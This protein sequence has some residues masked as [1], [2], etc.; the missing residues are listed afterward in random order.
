MPIL[1]LLP[2]RT[3]DTD[4]IRAAA[5]QAG[6]T[7]EQLESWRVPEGL[8]GQD[9]VLYGEPLF[10][11][12]VTPTLGLALLEP[13]SDWTACLPSAY[14]RREVRFTTLHEA[15][16]LPSRSFIKPADDKCFPAAV[17]ASGASLPANTC[18]LPDTTSVLLSEPIDWKVEFRCFVLDRMV[19]T[20][21]PYWRMG[22]LAQA[23]DGGWPASTHETDTALGFVELVLADPVVRLSAAVVVDVGRIAHRRWAV[24]EANAA[25]GSGIYGCDA[26]R[27]LPVLARASRP[28]NAVSE[29]DADWIRRQY[30]IEAA[31]QFEG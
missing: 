14:R 29:E 28:S 3:S 13:S 24:V 22:T 6:W 25:W 2:R 20:F 7:I 4:A 10:A 27:I 18:I 5:A 12:V 8:R 19:T 16:G 15:R 30:L 17:Y 11:D 31:P 1:I 21:S 9:L 26:S 23:D